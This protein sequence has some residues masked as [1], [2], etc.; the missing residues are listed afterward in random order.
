MGWVPPCRSR[1]PRTPFCPPPL[2]LLLAEVA[3]VS[4]LMLFFNN[5]HQAPS[6]PHPSTTRTQ[7]PPLP[8]TLLSSMG[9]LL[10]G[11]DE[12]TPGVAPKGEARRAADRLYS[13][14][15]A[16]ADL[17]D[18]RQRPIACARTAAR[19]WAR[20][21]PNSHMDSAVNS[22]TA[23]GAGAAWRGA[24]GAPRRTAATPTHTARLPPTRSASQL[25]V[26]PQTSRTTTRMRATPA[27]LQ[28]TRSASGESWSVPRDNNKTRP[29]TSASSHTRPAAA[30]THPHAHIITGL[31]SSSSRAASRPPPSP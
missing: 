9:S 20:P 21:R 15:R 13:R 22:R 25:A 28:P 18:S 6:H 26:Q 23:S 5:T 8:A 2:R 11:W 17:P 29:R 3:R 27:T 14:T 19:A 12:R 30:D 31:R 24:A 10:P 16:P 1:T 4:V 7:T